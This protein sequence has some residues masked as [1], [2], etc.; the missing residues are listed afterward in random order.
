MD[1][2]ASTV[3]LLIQSFISL[4][5]IQDYLNEPET[6]KYEILE[7][8]NTKFGFEDASMEWEAAETSF[9]LKNISIDFKLN[10][11]NAIIGPTGSG[12]SSLLLGLLGELNLLS[13]KYTYLQ[14]NPATT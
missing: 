7:Q 1:Q 12:K 3:S 11:L 10:S 5:R 13:G 6:R 8:S 9:K 4:E 14:L 2:I